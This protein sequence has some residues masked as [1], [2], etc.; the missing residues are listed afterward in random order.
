VHAGTDVAKGMGIHEYYR[1]QYERQQE[2]AA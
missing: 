1:L 2:K